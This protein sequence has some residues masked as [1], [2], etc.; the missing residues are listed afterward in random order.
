MGEKQ[1]T[2]YTSLLS[3]NK[4]SKF[5]S[6]SSYSTANFFDGDSKDIEFIAYH[7]HSINGDILRK[8]EREEEI[9]KHSD[10]LKSNNLCKNEGVQNMCKNE[11]QRK[12]DN[13][14]Y[15]PLPALNYSIWALHLLSLKHMTF[16][17]ITTS[18]HIIIVCL[19]AFGLSKLPY[20][21]TCT[22]YS[23]NHGCIYYNKTL[24]FVVNRLLR[25]VSTPIFLQYGTFYSP[26]KLNPCQN[27]LS[28]P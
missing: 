17:L 10:T 25:S 8:V 4:F 13:T 18:P 15:N 9:R 19:V 20:T 28:K 14:S 21:N 11:S 1:P 2:E 12:G 6:T 22:A 3:A 26:Q 5:L 23:R 16:I 24:L 27:I 7:S